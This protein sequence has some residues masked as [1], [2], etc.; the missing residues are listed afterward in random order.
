MVVSLEKTNTVS[1]SVREREEKNI[2]QVGEKV[3][4]EFLDSS[5]LQTPNSETEIGI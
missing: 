2:K 4:S 3:F 5:S 1:V